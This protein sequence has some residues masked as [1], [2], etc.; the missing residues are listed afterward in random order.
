MWWFFCCLPACCGRVDKSC[1]FVVSFNSAR[2]N[3][4]CWVTATCSWHSLVCLNYL[5]NPDAVFFTFRP[6]APD[7]KARVKLCLL[8][9]N[10]VYWCWAEFVVLP[11]LH[12]SKI[13]W[14]PGNASGQNKPHSQIADAQRPDKCI[15]YTV[16]MWLCGTPTH[17]LQP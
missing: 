6:R 3:C 16:D 5:L 10:D 9:T 15:Q 12:N 2:L 8:S 11:A 7:V 13:G 4:A 1:N 17:T 14:C